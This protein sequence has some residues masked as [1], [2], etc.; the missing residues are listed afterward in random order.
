MQVSINITGLEEVQ[1]RLREAPKI[2][3]AQTFVKAFDRAAGVIAAEV[4]AHAPEGEEELLKENIVTE[5][6][7]D[8]N[9]RGGVAKIGYRSTISERTGASADMIALWVEF[10]HRHVSKSGKEVGHVPAHPFMRPAAQTSATRAIEIFGET[11][12]D[13]LSVIEH[14]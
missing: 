12:I 11:V 6:T 4:A 8:S 5:V 7:L 2:L 1:R 3:V 10:G 13:S 14:S 9:M